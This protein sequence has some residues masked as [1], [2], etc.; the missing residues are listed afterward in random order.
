MCLKCA[1]LKGVF[2]RVVTPK[3]HTRG[4][5]LPMTMGMGGL[6]VSFSLISFTDS[7]IA[8]HPN[9]DT[10][11]TKLNL[12]SAEGTLIYFKAL[13]SKQSHLANAFLPPCPT[14]LQSGTYSHTSG[15]LL[16]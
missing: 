6:F 4:D 14:V 8:L 13:L 10:K 2:G 15:T 9:P 16:P 12:K 1:V 7:V 3:L 11:H 5:Q